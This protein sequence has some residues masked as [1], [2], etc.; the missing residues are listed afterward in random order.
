MINTIQDGKEKAPPIIFDLALQQAADTFFKQ[1][2][3]RIQV[4]SLSKMN[5]PQIP[6]LLPKS[7][8]T[9]KLSNS[10]TSR[11]NYLSNSLGSL[12]TF[13]ELIYLL[14]DC[15]S[16]K[17]NFENKQNFYR[18]FMTE[19]GQRK[20]YEINDN[21]YTVRDSNDSASKNIPLFLSSN[22]NDIWANLLEKFYAYKFGLYSSILAGQPCEV[23]YNF[24]DG[25]YRLYKLANDKKDS[26]WNF[27]LN[28][29]SKSNQ[30]ENE[31]E[32]KEYMNINS[33][34]RRK[35]IMV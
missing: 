17:T 25:E 10:S 7:I 34:E 28:H 6:T 21:I 13:E 22:G 26:I 32:M 33:H 2:E 9:L 35:V 18:I 3:N 8:D 20:V 23:I 11:S 5:H 27:L 24:V 4:V 31:K 29:F 19:F 12:V 15:D 16:P 14:L 30:T 1:F